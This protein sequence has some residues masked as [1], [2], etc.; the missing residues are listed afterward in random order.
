MTDITDETGSISLYKSTYPEQIKSGD[1]VDLYAIVTCTD[2]T[3]QLRTGTIESNGYNI[4]S[5]VDSK[6][7][8]N[9]NS[10]SLSG[11]QTFEDYHIQVTAKDNEGIRD[12]TISYTIGDKT[13]S[14]Q[15]MTLDT[16]GKTYDYKI[17]HDQILSS[18]PTISFTI[19]AT[20]ITGLS[21]SKMTSLPIN[22]D[23]NIMN[24]SPVSDTSFSDKN[25]SISISF[26]N[27]GTSPKVTYTLKRDNEILFTERKLTTNVGMA[28]DFVGTV[29]PGN[30]TAIATIERSEDGKKVNHEWHF[31]ISE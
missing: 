16:D 26:K 4:Y 19:T 24:V 10:T 21:T 15:K 27:G 31:T 28:M 25:L 3:V 12:V 6:P 30:Y 9:I 17:P 22:D 11:P 1:S 23:I 13:I 14:N 20:D 18:V 2:A 29:S 5:M 7:T 8:I